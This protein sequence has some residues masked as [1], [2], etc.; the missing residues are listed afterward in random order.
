MSP[1]LRARLLDNRIVALVTGAISGPLLVVLAARSS[2]F[3]AAAVITGAIVGAAAITSPISTLLLT[4]AVVPLERLGRFSNDAQ[5]VTF[6]LMRI[7]GALGIATLAI[8]WFISR[9]KLRITRPCVLYGIYIVIAGL[10]LIGTTDLTKGIQ[11]CTAMVGNLLF[12]L[13]ITNVVTRKEQVRLP[14]ILCL[15]TTLVVGVFSIYQW[16]NPNA[17]VRVDR[18][19][20]TGLRTTDERFSTVMEDFGEYDSIGSVRRVLGPTS[21][22]AVYG[23]NII[24][25][26]PFYFYLARTTR[27]IWMRLFCAAGLLVGSYNVILTNTRAAVLTLV[28]AAVSIAVTRLVRVRVAGIAAAMVAASLTIPFLP[29]MLYDRIFRASSYTTEHSATLRI[30][31]IYWQTAV[32]IFAEHWLLGCGIGNQNELPTRLANMAMPANSSAH[33]EYLESL[34]ETGIIGY[35]IIVAFMVLLYRSCRRAE[36]WFLAQGDTGTVLFLR[37]ARVGYYSVLFYAVQCDVLHF[38]LKGWW[39][40]MGLCVALAEIADASRQQRSAAAA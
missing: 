22:P 17:S 3:V 28:L 4:A 2:P 16:H 11:Q 29:S 6:S 21:S 25:T 8:H 39:L 34:I 24:L 35:P 30:R 31:L 18:Y 40:S 33:N 5:A 12:L 9:R 15:A 13:L 23:I 26:L 38:T 7:M 37:A 36:R 27:S 20:N 19:D 1:S 14:V 10:S 32:D